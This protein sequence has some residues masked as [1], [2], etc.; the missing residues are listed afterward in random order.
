M[1]PDSLGSVLRQSWRSLSK[2]PLVLQ[3]CI[4]QRWWSDLCHPTV[5]VAKAYWCQ[6]LAEPKSLVCDSVLNPPEQES[7][8]NGSLLPKRGGLICHS[9]LPHSSLF[10]LNKWSSPFMVTAAVLFHASV[11]FAKPL[12][13]KLWDCWFSSYSFVCKQGQAD[14]M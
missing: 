8:C 14:Y 13:V 1:D 4:K 3:L 7:W 9:V 10:T 2:H 12:E 5:H 6:L 11:Q